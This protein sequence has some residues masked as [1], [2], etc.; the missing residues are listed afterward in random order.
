MKNPLSTPLSPVQLAPASNLRR[1]FALNLRRR[2]E[3]LQ[4]RP[5]TLACLAGVSTAQVYNVLAGRCSPSLDWIDRVCMVL[6]TEAEFL[7]QTPQSDPQ[8]CRDES[9]RSVPVSYGGQSV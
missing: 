7:L 5:T 9:E 2:L 1:T 6:H 8:V 3:E 4:L